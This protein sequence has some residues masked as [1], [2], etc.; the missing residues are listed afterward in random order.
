M[1][2][3][4]LSKQL[5]FVTEIDKLK[6]VLRESWLV[7]ASR[8]ETDAEHSWHIALM[9]LLLSEYANQPDIDLFKVLKMLL[10][11]DIVEIDAGDTFIYDKEL[12][13]S[14]H[15]RE[16]KAAQRLFGLLPTDQQNEFLKLWKEYE[17]Q[18]TSEAKYARAIDSMQPLLLAYLNGG[19]SWRIHSIIKPQVIETKKHMGNGSKVLWEYTQGILED[20]VKKGILKE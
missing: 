13:K 20:A 16:T 3:I 1:D 11:H 18:S 4:R 10:I 6:Q 8:K 15:E 5:E 19:C 12:A 7:D 14:Q 17:A 9:A 2:S